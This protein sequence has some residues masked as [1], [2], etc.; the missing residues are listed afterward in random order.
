[1]GFGMIEAREKI[2]NTENAKAKVKDKK[3]IKQIVKVLSRQDQKKLALWAANLAE[4]ALKYFEERYPKDKRPR[5][6]IEAA[7]SWARGE[8]T[9]GEARTAALA[10]HA[11][12][13]NAKQPAACAAARAAGHAAATVHVSGHAVHAAAYAAKANAYATNPI[14]LK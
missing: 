7:K 2:E 9:T 8:I 14:L 6:A 5:K 12:A 13:R 1:M 11:A 10:A 4:Q 3:I